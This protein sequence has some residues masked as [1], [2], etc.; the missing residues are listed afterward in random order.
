[1]KKIALCLSLA[2]ALFTAGKAF[3]TTPA[4]SLSM[5]FGKMYGYGVSEQLKHDKDSLRLQK[6]EFLKGMKAVLDADTSNVGYIDGL[7]FG[8][9]IAQTV[10]QIKAREKVDIDTRLFL[11][12]FEPA[13][14]SATGTDLQSMQGAFMSLLK[15][16]S[17]ENKAKDP[18]A[19][20]NAKAGN[21][22][23]AQLLKKD[24]KVK[25]TPSGLCYKVIT[26]GSGATFKDDDEIEVKYRGTH[27]DG[28]EFDKSGDKTVAMSPK[29]VV[30]G[31]GEALKMMSPGAKYMVYIPSHLAYGL[32]GGGPI[33][34]NETLVF[35]LE[36]V[37]L[38]AKPAPAATTP[39]KQAEKKEAP[40]AQKVEAPA[41]QK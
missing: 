15:R 24:K 34:A 29:G 27:I 38:K 37:G 33:K 11:Q 9:Q 16:V 23:L 26:K 3:A 22:F 10:K 25:R 36:T 30:P 31:F 20:A 1:M 18:V 5:T 13:F 28:S 6:S 14:M 32:N 21:E 2:F 8:T 40:E 12:A 41:T 35:E 4:D 39:A 7:S 17:D 19:I